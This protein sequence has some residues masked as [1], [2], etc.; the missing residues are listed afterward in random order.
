MEYSISY[1]GIEIKLENY[2]VKIMNKIEELEEKNKNTKRAKD[3]LRN[4]YEFIISVSNREQIEEVIGK[5][6]DADPNA[7]NIIYLKIIKEYNKPLSDFNSERAK[8]NM[9]KVNDLNISNVETLT[10]F[11]TKIEKGEIGKTS[12]GVP[13]KRVK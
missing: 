1:N 12:K 9:D 3:K 8:E 10:K 7:I 4:I 13:F 11:L 2:N 5:F 6:D